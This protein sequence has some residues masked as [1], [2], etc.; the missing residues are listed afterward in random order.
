MTRASI[1][2]D[3]TLL[4][5]I[6]NSCPPE[7]AELTH[8]RATTKEMPRASMQ[9]A[10][11]QGHFL[12]F[13]VKLVQ[14]RNVLEIGTFT[15]YSSLTMALALPADGK[16]VTCDRSADWTRI[17]EDAWKRGGVANKIELRLGAGVDSLKKLEAEGKT[18]HFDL[19]FIDADKES[20]D[21]YYESCLVL[22]RQGGLIVLD[23]MFREGRVA[24]PSVDHSSVTSIRALN[25]K[26]AADERVDRVLISVGDGMM[27]VR[28]R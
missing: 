4:N 26:I 25:A 14:A 28:P 13:L 24:D 2:I 21:V 7:H 20:Y 18:G 27:L 10:P 19:A 23:N 22:V 12:S 6:V 17:A 8:L 3:S 9:I 1:A 11:E 5:Y 16:V 15:G